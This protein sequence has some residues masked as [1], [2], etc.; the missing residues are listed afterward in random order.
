MRQLLTAE[1]ITGILQEYVLQGIALAGDD[2]TVEA[3]LS[4]IKV[5]LSSLGRYGASPF[6]VTLYGSG[7]LPQAFCR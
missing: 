1:R 6:L 3:G 5:F 4:L 2:V 7:E